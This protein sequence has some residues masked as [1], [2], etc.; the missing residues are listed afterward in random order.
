MPKKTRKSLI[1]TGILCILIGLGLFKAVNYLN[2]PNR[3]TPFVYSNNALL[4]ELWTDYKDNNIEPQSKR[5]IDK[6]QNNI[7]TSEGQSYTMLRAAWMDDKTTF[8]ESW[9]FTVNNMQRK[10]D[11]LI[12]W[13]YGQKADGSYGILNDVGGNNTASDA[14]SDIAL[15]LLMAYSRWNEPKYL[16]QAKEIINSIWEKEVVNINGKPVLAANDIE[17]NSP[18]H[19]V[20]NPSYF[21][22]YAYRLFAKVDKKHD[23]M[24]LVDNS[25]AVLDQ[26]M[27]AKFDNNPSVGLPPN[28]ITINRTTGQLIPNASPNLDTN[29]GYDAFRTPWRLALDYAWY[30]DPRDLALL[31][32][33]SFLSQEWERENKLKTVYTHT[34][35]V[36]ANYESPSM[37]GTSIAYFKTVKPEQ[38]MTVYEQKL[39]TLYSPDKQKWK[40]PLTYYE[41][42]WAWFGIGLYQNAL[43]NIAEDIN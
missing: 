20:V 42:N 39:Q 2:S 12:A 37:Y 19:I 30:K 1:I 13:K 32:K 36:A 9:Q 38:G 43:P 15:A 27:T 8:D 22:P 25:Y 6:T 40:E 41:D 31:E 26:V 7:T 18:T 10:D 3:G 16:Y 28:W 35:Q 29:Y 21:S 11:K 17:R 24:S 23:W 14:D 34:G 5:T 4:L 33:F